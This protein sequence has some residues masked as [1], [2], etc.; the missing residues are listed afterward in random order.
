MNKKINSIPIEDILFWDLEVVREHEN[1]EV[2]S[3][4]FKLFRQ[5]TKNKD[6]DEYLSDE[7][8]IEQYKR[9]ASLSPIHNKIVCL[10]MG[11]VKDGEINV[12]SLT[13]TQSEIIN[14]FSKVL[15]KGYIPCG[16]NIVKFDF[17][18]LRAKA[19][20]EGIVD[21]APDNFNDA[22]K[23]EWSMTEV[24]YQT[25]I[26]DLM[27][28]FQGSHYVPSSLAEVCYL[29]N[30]PTPKDDIDGSEVSNTYYTE[31]VDR[32]TSYCEKDV[33]ACVHI[34]QRM[35]G[36]ELI[37]V[38]V[39]RDGDSKKELNIVQKIVAENYLSDSIKKE[40]LDKLK[41]SKA[42]KKMRPQLEDILIS[43]YV[44]SDFSTTDSTAT[45]DKET[46][47]AKELEIKTLLDEYFKK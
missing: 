14:Q 18:V 35:R 36:E 6:T 30:V 31:G 34:L 40:I 13:G 8:V 29:L 32:I 42:T 3:E 47:E 33:V 12:K 21:Y 10:S 16:Y 5:K 25:N 27:L 37:K 28:Q 4:A 38:V 7:E 1:L 41:L 46:A 9:K 26:I 39:K 11:F 23:K 15:A 22:G 17:P 2:G 24:K 44:K 45:D 20:Q 19:F 43:A